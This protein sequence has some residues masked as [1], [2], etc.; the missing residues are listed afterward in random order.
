MKDHGQIDLRAHPPK[1]QEGEIIQIAKT[2]VVTVTPTTPVHDTIQTMASKHFRRVPVAGAG[3]RSLE[4]IVTATDIVNYLGG[5]QKFDIIR[6]KFDGNFFKAI[7]EAIKVIMTRKVVTINSAAKISEAIDAMV[8]ANVGGMPIVD[9]EN[10]VRAIFTE[11]DLVNL[12]ADKISGTTVSQ[13]M[14]TKTVTALPTTTIFEAEKTMI[15][16]GFRRLPIISDRG[17]IG[18]VTAM[19]IIRF[20]ASGQAFKRLRSGTIT[21]VL[22]TPALEIASRDVVIIQPNDDVGQAAKMM[23][24]RKVGS[25]PVVKDNQ[26]VGILTERDFFKIIE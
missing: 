26:I 19:D 11:R 20:F 13:L 25:L 8:K 14:S 5:G 18:M 23:Q 1:S 16:E 21:Q 10:R 17:I 9:D 12:F 24:D 2:E 4:G 15:T 22:N 7:N 6:E 3:T